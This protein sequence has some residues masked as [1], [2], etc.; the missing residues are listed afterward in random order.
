MS[1]KIKK[2]LLISIS[3]VLFLFLTYGFLFFTGV[4]REVTLKGE[5][6]SMIEKVE[7]YKKVNGFYPKKISD[8]GFPEPDES[9]PIFYEPKDSNTS[10]EIYFGMSLGESFTYNSKT[11]KWFP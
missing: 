4:I 5:S 1:K 2:I 8:V 6:K 10:Y 7:E 9:G 3:I 11:Q